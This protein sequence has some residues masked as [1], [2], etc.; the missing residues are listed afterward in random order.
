MAQAKVLENEMFEQRQPADV[1]ALVS[2]H[3]TIVS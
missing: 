3:Q 1:F 2:L